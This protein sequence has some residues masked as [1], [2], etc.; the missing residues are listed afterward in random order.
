MDIS[1]LPGTVP[2]PSSLTPEQQRQTAYSLSDLIRSTPPD[3]RISHL[4]TI[5][6]QLTQIQDALALDELLGVVGSSY[7]PEH[8]ANLLTRFTQNPNAAALSQSIE[9]IK[10]LNVSASLL[11]PA[12]SRPSGETFPL[13]E[14]QQTAVSGFFTAFSESM[15]PHLN[16]DLRKN[17]L[18]A[19]GE[20]VSHNRHIP[21]LAGLSVGIPQAI[22]REQQLP[23]GLLTRI[24]NLVSYTYPPEQRTALAPLI[25]EQLA[26]LQDYAAIDEALRIARQYPPE[27]ATT[28]LSSFAQNQNADAL[29]QSFNAIETLAGSFRNVKNQ[30]QTRPSEETFPLSEAQQTAVSGFFTAF[31]E[32]MLPHL[33]VDL[34]RNVLTAVGELVS[35]N[36]HIPEL[37]GLSVGIPQAI[38]REQQLPVGLL[39]RINNLVS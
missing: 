25:G 30:R 35:H 39:T 4:N 20:L 16:V 36:R 5:G 37:A 28:I 33:N 26:T 19:V 1:T 3:Q 2:E 38:L 27:Q 10:A 17:V 31:S 24:N 29:A 12:R 22:L 6:E 8:T 13:S 11:H 34:R 14:A 7:P 18:T 21:E 32:S 23:V 9:A 15:L